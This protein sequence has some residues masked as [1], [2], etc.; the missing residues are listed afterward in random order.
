MRFMNVSVPTARVVEDSW[1]GRAVWYM[2]CAA[3]NGFKQGDAP[4]EFAALAQMVEHNDR[5][6][7]GAREVREDRS[8]W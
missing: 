6:H 4:D 7:G 1:D 2:H 3:C 8:V 5:V